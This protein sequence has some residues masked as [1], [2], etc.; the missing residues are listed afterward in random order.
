MPAANFIATTATPIAPV[1]AVPTTAAQ[2][3]LW[4]G[5]PP[6]G[7]NLY[8][9]TVGT[10]AIVT[11][12]AAFGIQLFAHQSAGTTLK[13]PSFTAARGPQAVGGGFTPSVAVAGSAVTITNDSLWHP[14]SMNVNDASATAGIALGNYAFVGGLYVIPPGGTFSLAVLCNAAGTATCNCYVTWTEQ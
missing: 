10:S 13:L 5:A 1:T 7:K 3:A 4:N 14:C 12:G 9:Q 2:F 8:I 6:G 11:S